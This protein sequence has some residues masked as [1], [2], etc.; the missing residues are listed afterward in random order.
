[1]F[2]SHT[3]SYTDKV[4]VNAEKVPG[5]PKATHTLSKQAGT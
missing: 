3:Q 2:A 5:L 1:V 4:N